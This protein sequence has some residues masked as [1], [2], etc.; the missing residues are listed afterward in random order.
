M[1]DAAG[2]SLTKLLLQRGL[3]LTYAIAFLTALNQ[4]KPLLGEKGLLPVPQFIKQAR[5]ID[6]PSLFHFWPKDWA[7]SLFAAVGLIV[8]VLCLFGIP[9]RFG[10]PTTMIAWGLMWL[11]YLSFVNVGQT[12]YAFGWESMLLEAGFLAIFL[13]GAGVRPPVVII[14]L[15]RWM[16]FRVMLGAGLIKM[17]GDDCWKDLTCLFWHYE[18]QPIPNPLSWFFH[19]LPKWLLKGGVI[20]NHFVELVV[21]FGLFVPRLIGS[22]AALIT[23]AFHGMLLVSGNFAFLTLLTMVLATS[24]LDDRTISFLL[25]FL[26]PAAAAGPDWLTA[27]SLVFA[28]IVAVL[29]IRPILNLLSPRQAMNASYD[30]LH[31]VGTYGA[32]GSITRPRYEVIVEGTD[33][34]VVN[35]GTHWREY[36]FKGKPGD[37]DR[38]PTQ[39]APY[40]L[41]IDW[42]MWFAAFSDWREHPWF[43]N[44]LAKLLQD[45]APTLGLLRTNPFHDGPPKFVQARLYE[46]HFTTPEERKKTGAWWKRELV[47]PYFPPVS[48]DDEGFVDLLKSMGW[49]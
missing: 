4:F 21:P 5:F 38:M 10:T 36:G 24:A 17:R 49:R 48:L 28:F 34:P 3:A 18:T 44:F 33:E 40:H 7:L 32:F 46:Y 45:D 9:E 25:P 27:A 43:V 8:A 12:F 47:G 22:A 26:K 13:G 35:G 2:Y 41:R 29:S 14:W 42:L 6:Y 20:V 11:L 23:I 1:G 19:W 15:F 31:L 30:P 39:I 16:I 37:V